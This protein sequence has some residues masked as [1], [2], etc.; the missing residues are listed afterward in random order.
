MG[1]V[2][3][4]L[5]RDSDQGRPLRC[6][7]EFMGAVARLH[8]VGRRDGTAMAWRNSHR[9]GRGPLLVFVLE[10]SADDPPALMSHPV[11]RWG[12]RART[13]RKSSRRPRSPQAV[14]AGLP[15][16]L[17]VRAECR[18]IGRQAGQLNG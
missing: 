10:S 15:S 8:G 4:S 9:G 6:R 11:L 18:L 2:P 14:V 16:Q 13:A 7:S 5:R 1:G 3:P 17:V 12:H